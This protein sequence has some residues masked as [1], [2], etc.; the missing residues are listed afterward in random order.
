M[1]VHTVLSVV[2][3]G[4]RTT[5]ERVRCLWPQVREMCVLRLRRGM[6]SYEARRRRRPPPLTWTRWRRPGRN[7]ARGSALGRAAGA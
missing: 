7:G 6:Y 3:V 2:R 4:G 5:V 1:L